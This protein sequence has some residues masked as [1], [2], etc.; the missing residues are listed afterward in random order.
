MELHEIDAL[1]DAAKPPEARI[2]LCLRADLASRHEEL[3]QRLTEL[4]SRPNATL[5]DLEQATLAQEIRAVEQQMADST[6][7]V[8]L[9]AVPRP[10]FRKLA[11]EHPPREEHAGDRVL[12]FN[13]ETFY[14][15]LIA[16]CLVEP[17]LDRPR[18]DRLLGKLNDGQYS[19]LAEAAWNLNRSEVSVPFSLTASRI[20]PSSGATSKRLPDSG[21]PSSGSTAGSRNKSRST[22][23]KTGG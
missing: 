12:G 11:A 2:P 20:A 6:V 5:A 9:R 19:A 22:S 1:L 16:L 21:S 10:D 18:V 3:D 15:A 14:E 8:L 13:Q 7:T 17:A 4:A 23:T